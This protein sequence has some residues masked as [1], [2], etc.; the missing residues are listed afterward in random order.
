MRITHLG[1]RRATR[2]DDYISVT[3]SG[4]GRTPSADAAA[5]CSAAALRTVTKTLPHRPQLE[6]PLPRQPELRLAFA[7]FV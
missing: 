1:T 2:T 3:T 6:P 4:F 7:R 5:E